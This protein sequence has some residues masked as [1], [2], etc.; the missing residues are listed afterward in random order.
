[1][2][3]AIRAML[4]TLAA[5][6]LYMDRDRLEVD[7]ELAA[8]REKLRLPTPI[9]KAIF[10]ALGERDSKA[11]I[12]RDSEDRPEPDDVALRKPPFRKPAPRA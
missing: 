8:K 2:Q 4:A 3:D 7:L 11:E 6:G 12:C 5:G 9:K 10:A 1:M